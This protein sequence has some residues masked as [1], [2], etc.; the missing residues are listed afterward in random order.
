MTRRAPRH[1]PWLIQTDP[2]PVT[3]NE[4]KNDLFSLTARPITDADI[5]HAKP[6]RP[7]ELG[8]AR[9]PAGCG[10]LRC[11]NPPAPE[12]PRWVA[13][14]AVVDGEEV[15]LE[16]DIKELSDV[17]RDEWKRQTEAEGTY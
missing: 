9:H 11:T 1:R 15:V 8:R 12:A 17:L 2:V 16:I 13:V 10:C 5:G 14:G 3:G 4:A 6:Y 7:P